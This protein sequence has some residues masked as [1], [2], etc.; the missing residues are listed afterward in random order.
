MAFT[1][2]A[3][4]GI[5]STETV[6][7]H[8]LE[9]LNNATVGGVL[10][11]EDV[12]NV[13]SVGLI[14]ARNGIK[15]T[16][17][18]IAMDTAGNITLGDS[19]ASTDDRLVFGA[20]SDLSIFHDGSNSRIHSPSHSLFIRTGS[21][22]GFF[23]GDGTENIL[24]G[25]VNGAVE[26]YYD[27]S[28]KFETTSAGATVTGNL[29]V[30][31]AQILSNGNILLTDN[32][33][34]KIGTGDDL[35][36]YHDGTDSYIDNATGGLKI[37][38]DTI[39]L[40]GK[41]ADE[42]MVVASV[43]GAVSLYYDNDE[44]LSTA[45]LGLYAK[46]IMPSSHETFDIGQNMGRWNDIYI[47]DNGKLKIGQDNDLQIYHSSS[48]AASYIQNSQ[49]NLFIEAP[50][51][52]A[53]KLRKNGTAETMLVATAGGS[54]ELYHSNTKM[55]ETIS[56]G[57]EV[58]GNLIAENDGAGSG[59]SEIQL[60]PYGTDA[61]I[62]CTA[63]GS[64]YTR[65]GSGYDIRTQIDGSGNFIVQSGNLKLAT[66][67]KGIDFSSTS[68]AAGMTSELFDDYE[69]GTYT[70]VDGSGAGLSLTNNTTARYTKIGRMVYVQFDISWPTTSNSN[71][72]GFTMP[73]AMS[74]SYGSGVIGWTDNGKPLFIH[75]GGLIY[76]MDNNNSVGNSSQHTLN[77][78][79]S[80]K[81][82]IGNVWYI[83]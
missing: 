16:S 50:N 24:K 17:G 63:S 39:R 32:D 26:L 36:I 66:A 2:I 43:N 76:V 46:S 81:R 5:G 80:G 40:K 10:T 77:S 78:E 37:L 74:V 52:S 27:N 21:V 11:Y 49:G 22:A 58:F 57:F 1:K 15:V 8:S 30:G 72:A 62:N 35:Q 42:N 19:G 14:T 65:M 3:A 47:A 75:V 54:I 55:A 4:A 28:K 67:G 18:D 59:T 48:N 9:V 31:T 29:T 51:G 60:Q 56:N 38:G 70:P 6:T 64:L 25:T 73:I 53:V 45:S 34:I 33:K 83:A 71:T 61:Y 13:D 12:T 44:K 82:I 79:L 23:N 7:L 69:E 68:D 41:S 20:S